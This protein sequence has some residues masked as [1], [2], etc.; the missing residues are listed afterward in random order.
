M[1]TA[2][3]L[4]SFGGSD[5]PIVSLRASI[6]RWRVVFEPNRLLV[7]P[8]AVLKGSTL[9]SKEPSRTYRLLSGSRCNTRE[10]DELGP[11]EYRLFV[12]DALLTGNRLSRREGFRS[13]RRPLN[14]YDLLIK[15]KLPIDF[16]KIE[17]PIRNDCDRGLLGVGWS[18]I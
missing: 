7:C 18:S 11:R 5:S 17:S 15:G 6:W 12:D 4:L 1:L 10:S 13:Q 3:S 16:I 14:A 2:T 8:G 9:P